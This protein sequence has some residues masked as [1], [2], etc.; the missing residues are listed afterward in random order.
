MELKIM[1][2]ELLSAVEVAE[3]FISTERVC[4]EHLKLAHIGTDGND[5]SEIFTSDSA[6]CA[7]V[8]INVAPHTGA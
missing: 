7:K 5:R 1:K 6:A 3:N 4:M 2:K 8:R